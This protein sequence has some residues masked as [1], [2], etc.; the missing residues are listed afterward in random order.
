MKAN[1]VLLRE[2]EPKDCRFIWELANDPVVRSVSFSSDEIPWD[3]HFAWFQSILSS[4]NSL[5]Y[6]VERPDGDKIGQ[7]R[8]EL[9]SG[10]CVVSI[11]ILAAKRG[12]GFG[13]I[14]LEKGLDAFFAS[15]ADV[16]A[17][18]AY[19]KPDNIASLNLFER[20]GFMKT[21][22]ASI[23]TANDALH[24]LLEKESTIC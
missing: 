12:R 2:A 3:E 15:H 14:V 24:L 4:S 6:I 20:T 18:H 17:V 8:F 16:S 11:S 13:L 5:I 10:G 21:G 22:T 23:K 1:D 7:I 9:K 19:I